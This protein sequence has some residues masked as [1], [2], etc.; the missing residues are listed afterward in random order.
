MPYPQ[1]DRHAL[2]MLPLK[3]RNHRKTIAH[4]R[5]PIDRQPVPLPAAQHEL[6]AQCAQ[7]IAT[8]RQ[9]GRSVMLAY[10]A[11]AIKNGLGPVMVELM[12]RGW[13][14]HLATNGAGII[15]DWEFSY[16]G[17]SCE[18]VRAMVSIGQF[19]NWQETGFYVNLALNVGAY[20]GLGYGESLG[21]LIHNEGLTIPAADQL[22]DE[23]QRDLSDNPAQSAA[24][25]DLLSIVERFQLPAGHMDVAHPSQQYSVQANAYRLKIASTGHPMI[26]HDIIYNHPMNHCASLGRTAERDFLAYAEGVSR[27]QGGVYLSMGSAVMSPMIFEKSL[28]MARNLAKQRDESIDDFQI[29]VNDLAQCNWDWSQGEPPEDNPAYYLRYNKTFARMGGQLHYVQADNRDFLLT[30]MHELE[31]YASA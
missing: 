24:A 9:H 21:A 5:V 4:D 20:E 29:V 2:Q 1:L 22:R 10:G 28:S 8:A 19:G 23:V 25:A 17:Q 26:G 6:L 27:L 12:Q 15:H 3:S 11:H 18:D 13:L 16:I 7:R 31:G 30:L 14:T